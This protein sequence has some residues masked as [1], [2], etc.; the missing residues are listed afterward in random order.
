[1]NLKLKRMRELLGYARTLTKE[2]G[3]GAMLHRAAGFAARRLLP[4][5]GRYLPSKKALA[6]QR[7]E[8]TSEFPVICIL[9][10]LY[11]TPPKY[12][13]RF[14][15][16]VQAQTCGRWQLCLADASDEAHAYVGE[17]V[18]RR[19]EADPRI[20][21]RKIDNAGIAANTNAAAQLAEGPYLA[22]AD[23]DDELAPHA[24]YTMGRAIAEGEAAGAKPQFL[25]S[26]EALFR[27]TPKD[28]YVGHFKPDYAPEYLMACNYICHL[29]VFEKSLF[30]A[31]GGERPAC[32]GAQDHDLFLRMMDE[33]QRHDPA[34]APVHLPQVLYYWR[35]HAASTSGGTGAKPYVVQAAQKA[36]ADHLT[37]A[38][39]KG[40]VEEGKFSGLCHV[41]WELP[42][43]QPLVSILI[44]NKDHTDDLEKCLHSLYARTNYDRFEVIVIE[45]NST[46]KATFD[47]YKTLPQRYED[48][49]VVRYEGGFNFSAINN[50]GRKAAKGDFLLL[51][52]NDV[53]ILSHDWLGE[54]VGE[55]IQPGVA[56]CGAMLY[57]PDDTIQH[58]GVI[59]G[60]GGYA[61]HSHK[62]H[63]RGASGYMFRLATVQDYSAVTAACLL[64]RTEVYDALNGL[65]EEFTV[66]F[67]DVDFC[68]R[69][70]EAGWRIAWTPYAELY[71]YESKSRG[72]DEKDPVKKARFDAERAR[73]YARHGRENILRDPYYSPSLSLDYE[74]FRESA[75]LR[76]LKNAG[77]QL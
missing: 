37:A 3:A 55:A 23:H 33:M 74:D 6:A 71:H 53:E 5:R 60:L 30:E 67:N 49:R 22:L 50:F 13:E 21:Y 11:N 44:P 24:I 66:A 72:S 69:I 25:Y 17:T 29:A 61:G 70:R 10:P 51:L 14:L 58:A 4:H 12:L 36:V 26:D 75:D 28:A 42:D 18:R 57:Y 31:V 68:L 54:M 38:G 77:M 43:P 40:S 62:Y 27:R 7:A 64:V 16:S 15:G 65:D 46:D 39:R 35:V 20:R 48:C 76:N 56:A 73:L 52:N 32:D 9:T 2:Q 34:A 63:R 45:N 47:Y 19:A 41:R 8:D 59:T 1:M